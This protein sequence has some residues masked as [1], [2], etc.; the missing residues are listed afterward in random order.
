M[1]ITE[2][3][4]LDLLTEI[5]LL[6]E[7]DDPKDQKQAERCFETPLSQYEHYFRALATRLMAF[8]GATHHFDVDQLYYELAQKIWEHAGAFSPKGNG[9]EEI[10]K[11]FIAWASTILRNRVNDILSSFKLETGLSDLEWEK[12]QQTHPEPSERAKLV[13]EILE[14]MDPDDAEI[15]RWYSLTTPLDGREIRTDPQRSRRMV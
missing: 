4:A 15:L 11:Q 7:S 12:I 1:M 5:A 3:T 9:P 10:K 14:D 8:N 6:K 2:Q 13:A